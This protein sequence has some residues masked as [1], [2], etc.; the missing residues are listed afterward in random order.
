MEHFVAQLHLICQSPEK[1]IHL[2]VGDVFLGGLAHAF[3]V[4]AMAGKLIDSVLRTRA[5]ILLTILRHIWRALLVR[6]V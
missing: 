1:V 3:Q 5:Q 2:V 6:I 4:E